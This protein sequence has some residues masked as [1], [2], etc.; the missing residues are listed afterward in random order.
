MILKE[1]LEAVP[2]QMHFLI[3]VHVLSLCRGQLDFP[4]VGYN[5][6]CPW[7]LPLLPDAFLRRD[8]LFLASV[9]KRTIRS[10]SPVTCPQS[11]L[12]LLQPP[13]TLGQLHDVLLSEHNRVTYLDV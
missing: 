9:F 1:Q 11:W 5:S 10:L 3:L 4:L 2:L 6:N 13:M 7:L 12:S 8:S